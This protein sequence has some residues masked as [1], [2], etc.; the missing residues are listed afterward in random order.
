MRGQHRFELSD[1]RVCGVDGCRVCPDYFGAGEGRYSTEC[2]QRRRESSGCN[3]Q[4]GSGDARCRNSASSAK[5][6]GADERHRSRLGHIKPS[7]GFETGR[8]CTECR[9][10]AGRPCPSLGREARRARP[11]HPYFRRKARR[12]C[13]CDPACF[14]RGRRAGAIGQRAAA[15]GIA[16]RGPPDS[17][18]D[19]TGSSGVKP[20]S[21][22]AATTN[23]GKHIFKIAGVLSSPSAGGDAKAIPDRPRPVGFGASARYARVSGLGRPRVPG[24]HQPALAKRLDP[25]KRIVGLAGTA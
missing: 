23:H 24:R 5:Y 18:G 10:E 20:G 4:S 6:I 19:F 9:F 25:R 17:G 15:G 21:R 11:S 8:P 14:L 16:S 7:T 1:G 2:A 13:P 12:P 22:R 3:G